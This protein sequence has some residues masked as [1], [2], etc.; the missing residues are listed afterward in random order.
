MRH[1]VPAKFSGRAASIL[2]SLIEPDPGGETLFAGHSAALRY[3]CTIP[4]AEDWSVTD[5]NLGAR[6]LNEE[7]TRVRHSAERSSAATRLLFEIN[8]S[9]SG[10]RAV[11]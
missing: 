11:T 2:T 7:P 9:R 1:L 3:Y 10:R 6:R 4:I 5:A 8:T